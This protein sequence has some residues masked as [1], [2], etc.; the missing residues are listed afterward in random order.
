[1]G[2]APMIGALK[3]IWIDKEPRL[4]ERPSDHTFLA[5]VFKK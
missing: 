1:M 4:L 3:K 5:A 2:T